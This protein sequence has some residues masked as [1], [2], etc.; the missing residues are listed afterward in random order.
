MSP[1]P[2]N[3]QNKGLPPNLYTNNN[4]TT[5]VYKR[6]DNGEREAFGSNEAQAIDAAKQLNSLLMK[7]KDLVNQVLGNNTSLSAFIDTYKTEIVPAKELAQATLDNYTISLNSIQNSSM[8]LKSMRDINLHDITEFLKDFTARSSNQRRERL[9][10]LFTHAIDRGLC[11]TNPAANKLKQ[12]YKK[13]KLKHTKEGVELIYN[14]APQWLKNCMD[15]AMVTLQRREDIVK[16]K[17]P[18]PDD[19]VMYVIQQ[20][21]EKYDTGYLRITIGPR[22]RKIINQCRDDLASPYL[23]HKKN[24]CSKINLNKRKHWTEITPEQIT[25]EFKKVRIASGAYHH[26]KKGEH[27]TFHDL[28]GWGIK[29][30]KDKGIDPQLLAGHASEQITKNYDA[31]HDEIRWVE[32]RTD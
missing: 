26:M 11:D 10:D 8:A 31:G 16:M 3:K 22:L 30:Y 12:I 29:D 18:S 28:R 13:T 7:G 27:P 14:S 23:V 32:T 24:R 15:V 25:R 5:F 4:G 17:L 1:R 19:D 6:P 21:T 9:V 2:R 20:K